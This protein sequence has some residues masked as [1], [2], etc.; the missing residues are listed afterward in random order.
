MLPSSN[1]PWTHLIPLLIRLP[2]PPTRPNIIY[3]SLNV[4]RHSPITS[5]LRHYFILCWVG[6]PLTLKTLTAQ[7]LKLGNGDVHGHG[8]FSLGS[9]P[10]PQLYVMEIP[11]EIMIWDLWL[12]QRAPRI[13]TLSLWLSILTQKGL[14]VLSGTSPFVLWFYP[15]AFFHVPWAI[16]FE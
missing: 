6:L 14:V 5:L 7:T 9:L 11:T 1:P 2:P 16:E 3:F 4:W 8:C 13:F 12:S 15:Y 10:L